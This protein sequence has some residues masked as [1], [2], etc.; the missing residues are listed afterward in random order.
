LN[1]T[2]TPGQQLRRER[3]RRNL[4]IEQAVAATRIRAHYLQAIEADQFELLPSPVHKRGFVRAYAE[5]LG[6][7]GEALIGSETDTL[8]NA[9]ATEKPA[10]MG[11]AVLDSAIDQAPLG[12]G[13]PEGAPIQTI[14]QQA[15]QQLQQKAQAI[16]IDIGQQLK[17]QR[18]LLG[19]SLED[20][21]RHT[22]LRQHYLV[23]LEA[24][25]QAGL[26]SPVQGRGMLNNYAAFLG[27][28]PDT[29]LLLFAEGLQTQLK[30][31][32]A[33]LPGSNFSTRELSPDRS[34]PLEGS[35]PPETIPP[36]AV[37]P[38]SPAKRARRL[39]S[40]DFLIGG[41][42]AVFLIGF[43]F[44]G[45]IRIFSMVSNTEPSPT[46]PSIA[47]VLLATSTP[48]ETP[49]PQPAT[50]TSPSLSQLFPT[51]PIATGT[52]QEGAPPE[53]GPADSAVQVYLTI[54]Q[55]AWMRVTVD[56]EIQFE[57]RVIPG[58][59]Y[60]FIGDSQVEVLTGNGAALQVFFN[61]ADLGIMGETGQ[62]VHQIFTSQGVLAP[63]PT[64]MPTPTQTLPVSATPPVQTPVP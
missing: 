5:Y 20:V 36:G 47:E 51:L 29:L 21:E 48:S 10:Q 54:Q 2:G 58:S 38:P 61:D 8:P 60:P 22:H 41:A 3:E 57:G 9:A 63:T 32:Q 25:D 24:G 28:N 11:E 7:D 31:R 46:A 6:L 27:L 50:P 52:L 35:F 14:G 37:Y 34:S 17:R 44:W 62:I 53:S 42:L 39:F 40:P 26:P 64:A 43:L 19:L 16:F 15:S 55:R 45:V 56:G 30:S 12:G 59:A 23:A 4:S 18:E 33:A 49:T 13:K 1:V